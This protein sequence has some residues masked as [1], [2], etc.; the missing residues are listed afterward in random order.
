MSGTPETS[1]P[2]TLPL[3]TIANRVPGAII[4]GGPSFSVGRLEADAAIGGHEPAE[5]PAVSA[6]KCQLQVTVDGE[7]LGAA[8]GGGEL[9]LV[10]CD[11]G[12]QPGFQANV[13]LSRLAA[14]LDRVQRPARRSQREQ[15]D[16]QEVEN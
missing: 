14:P 11:H 4:R 15:G 12:A 1:V 10:G 6:Q 16:E 9:A 8:V 13:H 3:L 7:R 5:L 2:A